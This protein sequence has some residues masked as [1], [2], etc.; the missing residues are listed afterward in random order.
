MSNQTL[1][2][3]IL[4][5][6][7]GVYTLYTLAFAILFAAPS[8]EKN[9]K[10]AAKFLKLLAKMIKFVSLVFPRAFG[11]SIWIL[12]FS[13]FKPSYGN[14]FTYQAKSSQYYVNMGLTIFAAVVHVFSIIFAD[15]ML[16]CDS[17]F[18][19]DLFNGRSKILLV[20]QELENV[21]F[22]IFFVY[23]RYIDQ[24]KTRFLIFLT[25]IFVGKV[26]L[27]MSDTGFY[28]HKFNLVC[29]TLETGTRV[30][31]VWALAN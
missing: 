4:Y 8:V 19:A 11:I 28:H 5:V 10:A 16:N 12:F 29:E 26:Y 1:N 27:D 24:M 3:A 2:S 22:G 25:V 21:L 9:S 15:L 23:I 6:V 30:V 14:Y 20:L 13:V 31:S 17:P 7:I 18:L